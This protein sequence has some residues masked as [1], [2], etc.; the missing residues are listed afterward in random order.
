MIKSLLIVL[1]FCFIN[2]TN[3][4]SPEYLKTLN[5]S[6]GRLE[7]FKKI[8][9]ADKELLLDMGNGTGFAIGPHEI[10]TA[11]HVCQNL[12]EE[13]TIMNLVYFDGK[14]IV[15]IKEEMIPI[16]RDKEKDLC[17]LFLYN[18]PLQWIE[19]SKIKPG[20]NDPVYTYGSPRGQAF[21]LTSGFYGYNVDLKYM[22]EGKKL[23]AH[24][25]SLSLAAF[26]G[27]SGGP[28]LNEKGE[29][30]GILIAIHGQY[31]HI[32]YT[33]RY[34]NIKTFLEERYK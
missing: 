20:I 5:L 32:S 14:E 11:D 17:I 30:V 8:N 4:S 33:P 28:I 31:H 16:A 13:N 3:T 19:F 6:V 2:C 15:R 12:D 25:T 1:F 27:N 26:Y 29:F 34:D 7:V 23:E 21:T 22:E 10:M 9:I 18:N 24:V